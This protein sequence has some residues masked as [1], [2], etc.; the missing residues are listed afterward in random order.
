[1]MVTKDSHIE[2]ESILVVSHNPNFHNVIGLR[3]L[4]EDTHGLRT[5]C[6]KNSCEQNLRKNI[7]SNPK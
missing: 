1:M 2:M 6:W 3:A 4:F 5:K 7:Q